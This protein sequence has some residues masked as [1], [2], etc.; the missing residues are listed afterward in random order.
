MFSENRAMYS[1]PNFKGSPDRNRR[2]DNNSLGP[3]IFSI[4]T[5]NLNEL[6][7]I[8][9]ANIH[10]VV[11]RIYLTPNINPIYAVNFSQ[12]F[13]ERFPGFPK[14]NNTAF[15]QELSPVLKIYF[16]S[17]NLTGTPPYVLV[18][19]KDRPKAASRCPI[20]SS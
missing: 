9:D 14:T 5:N 2:M 19:S 12:D 6:V 8:R 17:P 7:A 4:L 18:G 16:A 3:K 13:I 15:N 11:R 1:V 10:H 20:V